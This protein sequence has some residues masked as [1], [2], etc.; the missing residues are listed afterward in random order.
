MLI[1]KNDRTVIALAMALIATSPSFAA[2]AA[3]GTTSNDSTAVVSDASASGDAS[4]SDQPILAPA[5]L[6]SVVVTATRLDAARAGIQTQTGASTYTIDQAASRPRRAA[7][8]L[9]SIR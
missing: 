1:P 9:S 2:T 6:T 5:P 4:A 3:D 7:T 8:T